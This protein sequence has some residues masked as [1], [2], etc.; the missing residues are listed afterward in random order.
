MGSHIPPESSLVGCVFRTDHLF[1]IKQQTL[2]ITASIEAIYQI[3][4]Q[5]NENKDLLA[6]AFRILFRVKV[7]EYLNTYKNYQKSAENDIQL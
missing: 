1:G 6:Q 7:N 4:H 2:V 5:S 3:F